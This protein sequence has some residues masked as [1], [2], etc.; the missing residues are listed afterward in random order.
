M[1]RGLERKMKK[2]VEIEKAIKSAKKEQVDVIVIKSALLLDSKG[3]PFP[4]VAE[5]IGK[6]LIE[7]EEDE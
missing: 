7:R 5:I 2:I 3:M 4:K 1:G 6:A